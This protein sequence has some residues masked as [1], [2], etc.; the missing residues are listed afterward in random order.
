[1][2]KR[3]GT[4]P[5]WHQEY[6]EKL[7]SHPNAWDLQELTS[8][9]TQVL[10]ENGVTVTV[11]DRQT[12]V[13]SSSYPSEVI[14][15]RVPDGNELQIFCKFNS[16]FWELSAKPNCSGVEHEA[17][18]YRCVLKPLGISTP[19]YYGL[20]KNESTG[21]ACLV[22]E[23]LDQAAHLRWK[24]PSF[25][26]KAAGWIGRFHALN[27]KRLLNCPITGHNNYNAEYYINWARGTSRLA[28]NLHRKY[29]W[30]STLCERFEK[31]APQYLD[32]PS[33]IIHGE[34]YPANIL[35]VDENLRPVDWE[36]SG[37]A[38]GELDLAALTENWPEEIVQQ[39]ELEYRR[40]RWPGG[41]P[42]GFEERLN[43]AGLCENFR[44]LGPKPEITRKKRKVWRYE[45]LYSLGRKMGLI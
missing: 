30:L 1:M 34:Y 19:R 9:L 12:N 18:I 5:V 27:E 14:T 7:S 11:L 33:T 41:T 28:G 38:I 25:M 43:V 29:P 31:I 8:C 23:Y 44:W 16:G 26:K 35:V 32:E 45:R 37:I 24:N 13:Y 40:A 10:G 22:L 2:A 36:T 6:L 3:Y 15:C 17:E 20:Y 21:K 39:C 4:K 42:N